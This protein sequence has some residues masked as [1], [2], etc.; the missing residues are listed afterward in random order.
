MPVT[1]IIFFGLFLKKFLHAN[2][3]VSFNLLVLII[4]IFLLRNL[5][6]EEQTIALAPFRI[7]KIKRKKN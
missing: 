6:L 5:Q 2:I 7:T 1:A 4:A 3:N